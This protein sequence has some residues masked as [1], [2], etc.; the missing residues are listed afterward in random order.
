MHPAGGSDSVSSVSDTY[1]EA[2]LK[3]RPF[4]LVE[5][6]PNPN[7]TSRVWSLFD[8]DSLPAFSWNSEEDVRIVVVQAMKD[9]RDAA[10][11]RHEV[12]IKLEL[13]IFRERPDL[14]VVMVSGYPIGVIEVK[15]PGGNAMSNPMVWGQLYDYLLRLS[16]FYGLQHVSKIP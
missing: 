14:W 11:L 5:S 3:I 2:E 8:I 4:V 1:G 7:I 6:I 15:K 10:G 13:G 16:S 12:D 9:I